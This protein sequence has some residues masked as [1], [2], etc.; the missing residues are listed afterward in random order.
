MVSIQAQT[1]GKL[2]KITADVGDLVEQGQIIAR[3]QQD[4]VVEQIRRAELQ[5]KNLESSF[6]EKQKAS[7]EMKR[8]QILELQQDERN[9]HQHIKNLEQQVEAQHVLQQQQEKLKESREKL[10][11]EGIITKSK[12]LE[13]ENEVVAI[14]QQINALTLEIDKAKNHLNA[15]A[16]EIKQINST[17][18]LDELSYTQQVEEIQL[19][20]RDLQKKFAEDS[21][22][23]SP[24]TGRIVEV[25]KK[26]EELVTAGTT[27]MLM[28]K[29]S[30]DSELEVVMY[31]S[32]LTGKQIQKGMSVQISP[33]IVKREEYGF[34]EGAVLEVDKYP[35]TLTT[36][37]KTLQN[38]TLAQMLVANAAPIKVTAQLFPDT[39]TV[40]GYKW[41]SRHGPPIQIHSGTICF[42]EVTVR[43]QAPATLVLPI[44]KKTVLGIQS[45]S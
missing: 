4:D 12:V 41:S 27:I 36:I 11:K 30:E 10:A 9:Q 3:I 18:T 22:I 31:F 5:R 38:Q 23:I 34:M 26:E 42:G 43:E 13:V 14:Q 45:P 1:S 24:Y 8:I 20:I 40:S 29:L 2:T 25:P 37:V 17:E 21:Q 6:K 39:G 44:L 28:E 15:V 33:S 32:P 19:E 7:Q 35:S 16:L